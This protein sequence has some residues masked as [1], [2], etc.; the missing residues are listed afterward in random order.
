MA[1]E[2]AASSQPEAQVPVV[3]MSRNF[4]AR[5]EAINGRQSGKCENDGCQEEGTKFC[6]GCRLACYCSASCQREAWQALH[7]HQC[8]RRF[9]SSSGGGGNDARSRCCVRFGAPVLSQLCGDMTQLLLEHQVMAA[10]RGREGGMDKVVRF[11][12]MV[13]HGVMPQQLEEEHFVPWALL[14]QS[15]L[16][17]QALMPMVEETLRPSASP[18]RSLIIKQS[19]KVAFLNLDEEADV[20]MQL[21]FDWTPQRWMIVTQPPGS[22]GS[23]MIASQCEQQQCVHIGNNGR[24]ISF[25]KCRPWRSNFYR[26]QNANAPEVGHRR[27]QHSYSGWS[28]S[29]RDMID[30]EEEEGGSGDLMSPTPRHLTHPHERP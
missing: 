22:E 3:D 8:S 14:E 29:Q 19:A 1:D 16:L 30:E 12:H 17:A 25:A 6:T 10:Q 4:L 21:S 15:P 9:L 23:I 24:N 2:S 7:K 13:C 11:W 28:L 5:L 20:N 27:T 18:S 26:H